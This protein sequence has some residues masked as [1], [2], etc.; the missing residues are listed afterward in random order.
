MIDRIKPRKNVTEA[1]I[2]AIKPN[3]YC[4]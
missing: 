1:P 3:D 4:Q 2:T